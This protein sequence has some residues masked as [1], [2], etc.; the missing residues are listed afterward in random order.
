M[1]AIQHQPRMGSSRQP[2]IGPS[3]SF[4]SDDTL[5]FE[6]PEPAPGAP[7]LSFEESQSLNNILEQ[8]TS[9]QYNEMTSFG[10]GLNF[11][12]EWNQLPP[13]FMGTATS[14]GHQPVQPFPSSVFDFS[15]G[16]SFLDAI[17]FPSASSMPP[18]RAPFRSPSSQ[19][20]AAVLTALQ[21]GQ[22]SRSNAMGRGAILPSQTHVR[23]PVHAVPQPH[24][25]FSTARNSSPMLAGPI[26]APIPLTEH[27]DEMLFADMAFGN[28]HGPE[29]QR[30]AH[31]IPDDVNFG[32]DINF[33]GTQSYVPPSQRETAAVLEGERIKYLECFQLNN[34]TGNTRPS[35]PLSGQSS[36]TVGRN[37]KL[38]GHQNDFDASSRKRKVK[39]E[40]EDEAEAGSSMSK[41]ARKRKSKEDLGSKDDGSANEAPGKRRRKS[42]V[43]GAKQARENLTDSQKR[44]NHIKSEQRR[45]TVIKEGFDDLMEMVP[46]LKNGGYSK[47]AILQ[48]AAEWL[49]E[50]VKGNELLS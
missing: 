24:P 28:P 2:R 19:N 40:A 33:R 31:Q 21:T 29:T 5:F 47:S 18:P 46:N 3:G 27:R 6:A 32:S 35:S 41:A 8:L 20:A 13:Q 34:S 12:S 25:R 14:Y 48:M 45:R 38:N 39:E 15:D 11:S 9:T 4:Y 1:L 49:D 10:E 7:L 50:L 26:P 37:G 36:P 16:P 23:Q 44:M 22:A 17:Q 43:N 42:N 30:V